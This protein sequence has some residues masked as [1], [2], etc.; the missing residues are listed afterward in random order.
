M[1]YSPTAL[2]GRPDFSQIGLKRSIGNVA[3]IQDQSAI[4]GNK[5]VSPD[6]QSISGVSRFSQATAPSSTTIPESIFSSQESRPSRTY[7]ESDLGA[8]VDSMMS[9][10]YNNRAEAEAVA[11]ADINRFGNEYLPSGGSSNNVGIGSNQPSTQQS[12]QQSSNNTSR[13]NTY[14]APTT[15][16][17]AMTYSNLSNIGTPNFVMPTVGV[18]S[19]QPSNQSNGSNSNSLMSTISNLLSNLFRRK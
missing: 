12:G 9:K 5:Q 17:N 6:G 4:T 14:T 8:I 19:N 3:G 16:N 15:S 1:S 18:G 11:R 10:G 13:A 2:A 7:S